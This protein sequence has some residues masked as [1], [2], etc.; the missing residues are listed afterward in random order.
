MQLH[1]I[2]AAF[3]Y[4][5]LVLVTGGV[6]VVAFET[7]GELDAQPIA[8]NYRHCYPSTHQDPLLVRQQSV[9]NV[10]FWEIEA[11]SHSG[12]YNGLAFLHFRTEPKGT[13]TKCAWLNRNQIAFR[14]DYLPE[15]VAIAFAQERFSDQL[16][17]CA[18]RLGMDETSAIACRKE[19]VLGVSGT[20]NNPNLLMPEEKQ[21][22]GNLGVDINSLK[23]V[24]LCS[25]RAKKK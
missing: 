2:S 20:V 24:P 3:P 11:Y 25:S 7:A 14:L 21:A 18:N 12:I 22:L 4:L 13:H 5:A 19:M 23:Y 10:T 17:E 8:A 9:N 15:P 16:E 1:R 6:G